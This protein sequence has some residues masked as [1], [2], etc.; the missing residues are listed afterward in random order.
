MYIQ[1]LREKPSE[2]LDAQ[3]V[4]HVRNFQEQC[5]TLMREANV[6]PA[7][8]LSISDMQDI[9]ENNQSMF[10]EYAITILDL[11]E[12]S[13]SVLFKCNV[14]RVTQ[15]NIGLIFNHFVFIKSMPPIMRKETG[16]WCP[17]CERLIQT[18]MSH[19]CTRGVCSQCKSVAQCHGQPV[20]CSLCRR[21][22]KSRQC[23]ENHRTGVSPMYKNVCKE[24][25]ACE[26]CS[27]NLAA[28]NGVLKVD[29]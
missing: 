15:L 9:I 28:K 27:V 22:L 21:V 11:N 19:V 5:R 3:R 10:G 13:N 2:F 6:R 16:F 29:K 14:E 4:E 7:E 8:R 24:V 23:F 25:I 26:F 20:K 18:K 12:G 1:G 17:A